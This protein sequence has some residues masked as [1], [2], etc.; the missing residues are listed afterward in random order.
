M[1]SFGF[2]VDGIIEANPCLQDMQQQ[3]SISSK[4]AQK[5]RATDC[6]G[7]VT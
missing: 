2:L 3:L 7:L 5:E 1:E 6:F 4:I